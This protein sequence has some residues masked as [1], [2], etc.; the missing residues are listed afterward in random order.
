MGNASGTGP[1]KPSPHAASISSLGNPPYPSSS[2]AA[3]LRLRS[4]GR[5]LR[6]VGSTTSSG[7]TFCAASRRALVLG[8]QN[9]R[10]RPDYG[11]GKFD[12]LFSISE[13][14]ERVRRSVAKLSCGLALSSR[15]TPAAMRPNERRES[16]FRAAANAVSAATVTPGAS[17]RAFS[18]ALSRS[19]ASFSLR[20]LLSFMRQTPFVR[21]IYG[22]FQF[23][24]SQP[25]K[26]ANS[27]SAERRSSSS[28]APESPVLPARSIRTQGARRIA[29]SLQRP[30]T[31]P[32]RSRA[33]ASPFW[34][35]LLLV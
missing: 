21:S 22:Q 33:N 34:I 4:L 2:G 11:D 23:Q 15:L 8:H 13:P 1:S 18:A 27:S 10:P 28:T 32:L 29:S 5:N 7:S 24:F 17:P 3:K 30:V 6:G 12:R 14:T 26:T 31:V 35:M 25:K 9:R 19:S 20:G 16:A